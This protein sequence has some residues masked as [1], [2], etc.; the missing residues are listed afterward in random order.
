MP[1]A[2]CAPQLDHGHRALE[3]FTDRHELIRAFAEFLHEPPRGERILFFHGDGGNGKSLLM[4]FLQTSASKLLSPDNWA[5]LKTLRGQEFVDQLAAAEEAVA[6]PVVDYDFAGPGLQNSSGGPR[7]IRRRLA[8]KG[9][10]F[11]QFDF[12]TVLYLHKTGSLDRASFNLP[13]DEMDFVSECVDAVS[14]HS[15]AAIAKPILSLWG[16]RYGQDLKL[17]S[18]RRKLDESTV[19]ALN[20][21]RADT[22]LVDELP[23]LLAEDINQ[24]FGLDGSPT[25]LALFF[26]THESFFTG[27]TRDQPVISLLADEWFRTFV[28]H[29][30]LTRAAVTVA[31]RD[32][33]RWPQPLA[34]HVDAHLVGHLTVR[35]ADHFLQKAGV[36]D[37]ALRAAVIRYCSVRPGEVHPLYLALAANVVEEAKTKGGRVDADDFADLHPEP[38]REL[39]NRLFRYA[40]DDAA[41]AARALAACRWFDEDLFRMLGGKMR[42]D[43]TAA[44]FQRLIRFSF[45]WRQEG[46]YRVHD[47]A[48]RLY[49]ESGDEV[50]VEANGRLEEHYRALSR[51][52]GVGRSREEIE[53]LAEAIYHRGR[54]S[55]DQGMRQWCRAFETASNASQYGQCRTLL[56]V[57]TEMPRGGACVEAESW[58]LEGDLAAVQTRNTEAENL[59]RA[60]LE[61]C[62]QALRE[63][64]ESA[65]AFNTKGGCLMGLGELQ[66]SQT[67]NADAESS[68]KAAVD[69]LDQALKLAPDLAVA[70][71]NKGICLMRL[72]E[73]QASQTRHA[74]AESSYKAAV[75]A[76]D[77]ALKLAPDLANAHNNKGGCLAGLG[78]IAG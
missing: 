17:W 54:S 27:V 59:Y 20:R 78:G 56:D 39:L 74:E 43:T 46:G 7:E 2:A 66:A 47:L 25:R 18:M 72:G 52:P 35:D 64:P 51:P 24:S 13:E 40:G 3:L 32:L 28:A 44:A 10:R 37:A 15:Y 11:P 31:G 22:E 77:Q 6:V 5:H 1:I 62:G 61:G 70:H 30:D 58:G 33:P 55:P 53:A 36:D 75:D 26:D 48:R 42:F 49:W 57:R 68:Y 65:E 19:E 34:D 67:R 73:L 29:L 60:A 12:A 4:R 38:A 69:A 23:R 21:L 45:I 50:T 14:H 16:K 76:L 9:L 63:D 71:N 8:G 41:H